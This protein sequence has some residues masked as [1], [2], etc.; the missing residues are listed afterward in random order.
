M[1]GFDAGR[2]FVRVGKPGLSGAWSLWRAVHGQHDGSGPGVLGL[3]P[4]GNRQPSALDARKKEVAY[5]AGK[6]SWIS[7][8]W[9]ETRDILT[10]Q[11]FEKRHRRRAAP[12]GRPMRFC[13][14]G[15]SSRSRCALVH[16]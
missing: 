7:S 2:G 3:P 4:I 9:P 5:K 1:L 14:V 16:R 15:H 12:A 8:A 10:R 11:A 13:I 6:R